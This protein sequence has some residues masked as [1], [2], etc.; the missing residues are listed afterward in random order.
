M[1]GISGFLGLSAGYIQQRMSIEERQR[2]Y[3]CD[4]TYATANEVGFDHLRDGLALQ[5]S[6]QVHRPFAAAVIDEA[7]SIL[8]DEAR[9]P[10]VIAG[11]EALEEPIA[12]RVD[13]LTRHFQRFVHYTLDDYGRNINLTDTGI[14]AVERAFKCGNLFDA[15][16]LSM[17]TAVQ[18]SVHAHALLRRVPCRTPA[19][20]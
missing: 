20:H 16:N 15:E 13:R 14:Q 7:D 2:A 19:A 8:I 5:P 4:I 17:L 6:E 12:V 9:I 3:A 11:G 10:L 1:T 18:D